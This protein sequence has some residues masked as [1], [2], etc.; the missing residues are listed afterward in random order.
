MDEDHEENKEEHTLPVDEEHKE[1]EE[2]EEETSEP[3]E[4]S[5]GEEEDDDDDDDDDEIEEPKLKYS[6]LTDHLP[7]TIFSNDALSTCLITETFFAFATHSGVLHITDTQLKLIRSLRAHNASILSLSTDG[8]YLASA[9][10]DGTV[11]IGSISDPKDVTVANFY[12]PVQSVALDPNYRSTK[13]FISGGMS[14]NVIYSEK[15]WL[16]RRTDTVLSEGEDPVI[17]VHWMDSIVLWMNDSGITVYS[18]PTMS[19]LKTIPKPSYAPRADLY[20]P[21]VSFPESNR[22]FIAWAD[23]IWTLKVTMEKPKM[24]ASFIPSSSSVKSLASEPKVEIE[25]VRTVNWLIGG[26]APFGHDTLMMLGY[27]PPSTDSSLSKPSAPPPELKLYDLESG[28]EVYADVLSLR[29]YERLGVNDYHLGQYTPVNGGG[30]KYY[31]LSARDAVL[32]EKRDLNDRLQWLLSHKMYEEAWSMSENILG[33]VERKDVGIKWVESLVAKEKWADAAMTLSMIL[34]KS[35]IPIDVVRQDWETWGWIFVKAN[36]HSNLSSVLPKSLDLRIDHSIYDS[37]LIYFCERNREKLLHYLKQW[38]VD[39]YDSAM[40]KR[41]LEDYLHDGVEDVHDNSRIRRALVTLYVSTDDPAAAVPHLLNLKDVA[42]LDLI[43]QYHLLPSLVEELPQILT[44][45]LGE[46][47]LTSAP[48]EIIRTKTQPAVKL[49]VEGRHEVVPETVIDQLQQDKNL[50]VVTFLYLERLN[51]VDSFFSQGFGDLQVKLYAEFDRPK[52][53]G[54][55]QKNSNYNLELA[56]QICENNDYITEL[57]YLL[58]MVGQNKRALR[59]IIDK[60]QDPS[61]AVNF[62]KAQKDKELWADLINYS[63][64]KPLFIRMLLEKGIGSVDAVNIIKRIPEMMEI[65]ELKKVLID[66]FHQKESSLSISQ[67]VFDIIQSEARTYS[68]DLRSKRHRG[69]LIDTSTDDSLDLSIP[70]V[71]TPDDQQGIVKTEKDLL[72][73]YYRK[74]RWPSNSRGTTPSWSVK[75]KIEHLAYILSALS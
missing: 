26:I 63:M 9:S 10:M 49:A 62:A 54:F 2:E 48:V 7:P 45:M 18:R 42:V 15:S 39:L 4:T 59:L 51:E 60:L 44:V 56:V 29:G 30:S 37:I 53:L 43:A 50:D 31:V 11:V 34:S 70:W 64:E 38:P 21:R 68:D 19:V 71:I 24:V 25:S 58:G 28:E 46:N 36:Q 16:G 52:L 72:G 20:K 55:I 32:A 40:I 13:A 1:E 65:P 61:E 75:H 69:D 57:V 23:T 35:Q 41:Q 47:E 3:A 5:S 22:I 6:R 12:R 67:G 66:I 33:A 14:G 8:Y 27:F 17:S 74:E 73:T